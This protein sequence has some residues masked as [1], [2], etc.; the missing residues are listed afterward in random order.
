MKH[1][2]KFELRACSRR[3]E[4]YIMLV[5]LSVSG[6][7]IGYKQ[8]TFNTNADM[9]INSPYAISSMVG[10]ISLTSIFTT[11]IAGAF[12]L[13][14][15]ADANFSQILY[16]TPLSKSQYLFTRFSTVF[17]IGILLLILTIA[18]YMAGQMAC[19]DKVAFGSFQLKAYLQPLIL[20]ALPNLFLCTSIICSIGWLTKN[21]LMVYCAG[22]F[23]YITYMVLLMYSGSPLLAGGL[24]KSTAA[25]SIA[26]ISDPFG[27]S[28]FY[29]QTNPWVLAKKNR[30][31]IT[32]TG[33]L[34][35]N[36]ILSLSISIIL[37]MIVWKF[38]SLSLNIKQRKRRPIEI[39]HDD[40]F[41]LQPVL[42]VT[43][44][45]HYYLATLKSKVWMDMQ[46]I[47]KSI[48]FTLI[49]V[50]L[51]FFMSMEFYDGI[52]RG[53]RLPEQYVTTGLL[54]NRILYNLPGMLLLVSL[55]Y[56]GELYWRSTESR[57][58]LIED[59]TPAGR[60]LRFAAGWLSLSLVM[61]MLTL[62]IIMNG[63][64]FQLLYQY[65]YIDWAV[66]TTL[67]GLIVTPLILCIGITLWVHK[68]IPYK[69]I[70][71]SVSVLLIYLMTGKLSTSIG[72]THP[73]L[74][75]AEPYA[76]KYSEM[77]GWDNYMTA[78][79]WK[80]IFGFSIILVFH[81][82][83]AAFRLI[84]VLVC[85]VSGIF[86]YLH[87][88][89]LPGQNKLDWQQS[90]EQNYRRYQQLPQPA[91]THVSANVELYPRDNRYT[92]NADYL[93][94]NTSNRC[95]D[96]LLV[97]F[98]EEVNVDQA[99]L[100]ANKE[101]VFFRGKNGFL[102]LRNALQP[103]DTASF[104][105]FFN[106][107]WN[108]FVGHKA[109]NAI[110]QN[111]SF[112]RLSNYFPVFGYRSDLEIYSPVERRNRS[113]GMPTP[114]AKLEDSG[115]DARDFI[116]LDLKIGTAAGQTAI[117]IGELTG[118]WSS[119]DRN[120]FNYHTTSPIPFRFGIA[121]AA[122]NLQSINCNGVKIEVYYYPRHY[123]NVQRLLTDA[124]GTL[125]Y[126]KK[127][128][129][130]YPF[131][132]IRF[133]EVSQFTTGFAGTCYPATIFMTENMIFH[134][135]LAGDRNQDVINE[136]AGHELSHQWW[137]ADQLVPD[138]REGAKLLTETL[139]MY[140]ELMMAKHTIG[141][142]SVIDKVAMHRQIYY[143]ERGFSK[144]E[145]LYKVNPD[146]THLYYSKG[147]VVMYKLS[148]LIGEERVNTALRNLLK[149]HIYPNPVPVTT[150]LLEELYKVS[151]PL[152][153]QQIDSLF[154]MVNEI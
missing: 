138:E 52:D 147:L 130:T 32:L 89:S 50:A 65:E 105:F 111:G 134:T 116:T 96:S 54:S 82:Q 13:F 76:G 128:F 25:M 103:G 154:K 37:L 75:F 133:A 146:N 81:L 149:K 55:F 107:H 23:L 110:V 153:K 68:V 83:R 112:I 136:L 104:H 98:D 60:T 46:W 78:F 131:K 102:L 73:L 31:Y 36:R 6:F 139:A 42:T 69:W 22:L 144:E 115:N 152:E 142:Q 118:T 66:Y 33:N 114:L 30:Q 117:G 145:P 41:R 21:K 85:L 24:P 95:M 51:V 121:S 9:L 40:K 7:L 129:G 11:T 86:I 151:N 72:I 58:N 148:E 28:A 124:A 47:L 67:L 56:T 101:K 14:K 97:N 135:N 12:T 20:I 91:I 64:I 88:P 38:F 106:Y 127:N 27:L 62:L 140:T 19:P 63:I 1:L 29:E 120:Y 119:R 93:I 99:Y 77:N 126:C 84:T 53:I 132:T 143:S 15:E 92:V 57:F 5:I 70:A 125:A 141:M 74:R 87:Y 44:G 35:L 123:E 61:I 108:P 3:P 100:I 2:L 71:F 94:Q 18:G 10:L 109:F 8:L 122:Y 49:A 150:T 17:I 90:Y 26:A 34:L 80:M 43:D 59:S 45:K 113:L 48:P 4:T 79:L 39:L 16:A 137:G